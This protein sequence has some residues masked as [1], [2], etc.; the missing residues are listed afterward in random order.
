MAQYL[1]DLDDLVGILGLIAEGIRGVLF[2]LA[3]IIL[4]AAAPG[5]MVLAAAE[6]PLALAMAVLL[7]VFLLNRSVTRPIRVDRRTA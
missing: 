1:D 3:F 4:T 2:P 7:F 5:A 6:P